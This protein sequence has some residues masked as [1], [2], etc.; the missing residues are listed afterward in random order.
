MRQHFFGEILTNIE[1]L[2]GSKAKSYKIV[3]VFQNLNGLTK[4]MGQR[5]FSNFLQRKSKE[6]DF[7]K[8]KKSP[9]L[10]RAEPCGR[11]SGEDNRSHY[12]TFGSP[13]KG[14]TWQ[15]TKNCL[16]LDNGVVEEQAC[17][18]TT[19]HTTQPL[20]RRKKARL[21]KTL[22]IVCCWTTALLKNKLVRGQPLTLLNLWAAAKRR[23]LARH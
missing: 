16:L 21:G 6:S 3:Q 22:K 8:S 19:A 1:N 15:D 5:K 20:G 13:Q 11:S 17:A 18:R 12:S 7:R 9:S 4:G 14:A 23:D 2:G 10:Q